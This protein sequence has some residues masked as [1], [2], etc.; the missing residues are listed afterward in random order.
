[1]EKN[2]NTL[3]SGLFFLA[4]LSLIGFLAPSSALAQD[5]SVPPCCHNDMVAPPTD[6]IIIIDLDT[7]IPSNDDTADE[8]GIPQSVAAGS[9]DAVAEVAADRTR[10]LA[11][12]QGNSLPLSEMRIKQS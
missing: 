9:I 7:E 3:R 6:I 12:S 5:D 11:L 10:L 8:D 2:M 1:M 4:L